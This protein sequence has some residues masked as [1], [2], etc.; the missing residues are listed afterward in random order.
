MFL[1]ILMKDIRNIIKSIIYARKKKMPQ[2]FFIS[3]DTFLFR[4]TSP[5]LNLIRLFCEDAKKFLDEDSKNV[6]AIHCLAGKGRTGTL[7]SCL[8]LYLN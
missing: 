8:L 7:I 4:T 2:I 5:P 3:K 6:V 1:I